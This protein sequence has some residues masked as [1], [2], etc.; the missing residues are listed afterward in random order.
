MMQP[1]CLSLRDK[2]VTDRILNKDI[3]HWSS[4]G[5][6]CTVFAMDSPLAGADEQPVQD[7]K[8]DADDKK[9]Q[10]SHPGTSLFSGD[11]ET[12]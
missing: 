11:Q 12:S 10:R 9:T 1:N 7:I 8:E 4:R 2:G 3:L 6:S 5:R